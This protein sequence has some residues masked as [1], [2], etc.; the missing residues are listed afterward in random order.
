[1]LMFPASGISTD[2]NPASAI[3]NLYM[4]MDPFSTRDNISTSPD[5]GMIANMAEQQP[6]HFTT[7]GSPLS[8]LEAVEHALCNNP[9]TRQTWAGVKEQAAQ[10]GA[11]QAAYLPTINATVEGRYG[12]NKTEVKGFSQ[13]FSRDNETVEFN[14]NL[15]LTWVLF[16]FGLRSAN[17]TNSR[18]L[19][20]AANATQDATLQAV[21]VSTAQAYYDLL[22]A[23]GAFKASL[24]SEKSAR[25]SFMAADAMYKAGTGTLAD[26]LQAQTT[27]A[28]ASLDR[29]KALGEVKDAHGTLA[30]AMGLNA[31]T[32]LSVSVQ[33]EELPN[34]DFVKSVDALIE[35]AKRDHPSLLA[36]QAQL[37]AA[38]AEVDAAKAEGLPSVALTGN[39]SFNDQAG[40]EGD[41]ITTNDNIGLQVNI[42]LLE[43]LG[44]SYQIQSAKAQVE[45]KTADLANEEQKISLEVW[46]SYQS[47][48]T[49][50]ENLKATDDLSRSATQS[51]KVAQGRY[52][53]GVGTIIELLSAQSTL[54]DAR[55]QRIQALSNWRTA[56]LKLASSLGKLGFWAI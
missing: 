1:M 34:T 50:T 30:I 10:V 47:L 14:Y 20:A 18:Y 8:L 33:G 11:S 46:K 22:S 15:N 26:K 7:P 31:N 24:D 37:Q 44:R 48:Q 29:V 36:A 21:F 49:E 43:G 4:N 51:F 5:K 3:D 52:K 28:Q 16:D 27:Y 54:A 25:K 17:L 2:F 23:M 35:N 42:P 9:Q 12:T 39:I 19:L 45:L 6:C 56:R 53:A 13:D 38:K 55:Q 41:T 32:P 40:T